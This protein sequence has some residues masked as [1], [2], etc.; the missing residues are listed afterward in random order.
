MTREEF[1]RLPLLTEADC[2]EG[3]KYMRP[4]DDT[5]FTICGSVRRHADD[6]PLET[7]LMWMRDDPGRRRLVSLPEEKAPQVAPLRVGDRL[8][9][10][11]AR[12][13][14]TY[15]VKGGYIEGEWTLLR[16]APTNFNPHAWQ[17]RHADGRTTVAE[18]RDRDLPRIV[19]RLPEDAPGGTVIAD[20]AGVVAPKPPPVAWDGMP[21]RTAPRRWGC[22]CHG[23]QRCTV[24][25][26]EQKQ[27]ASV[28]VN[29]ECRGDEDG[30][31]IT[32]ESMAAFR[33]SVLAIAGVCLDP[34]RLHANQVLARAGFRILED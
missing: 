15:T 8:T 7:V 24:H 27:R 32:P 9:A 29:A 1:G 14:T 22:P 12:A 33:D 34:P 13:G 10:E 5:V 31:P 6:V 18:F 28:D 23:Y 25:E 21:D 26:W 19:T 11:N 20:S 3:T 2:V 4:A 16:P 30:E 17:V